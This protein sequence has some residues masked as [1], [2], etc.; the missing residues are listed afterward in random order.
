M[1][2]NVISCG[3]SSNSVYIMVL[4]ILIVNNTNILIT[5]FSECVLFDISNHTVSGRAVQSFPLNK[6]TIIITTFIGLF[7]AI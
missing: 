6:T 1:S 2:L 4:I 7:V 5:Y 3:N